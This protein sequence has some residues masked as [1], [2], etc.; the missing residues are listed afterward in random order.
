MRARVQR[1]SH[2]TQDGTIITLIRAGEGLIGVSTR[3][4]YAEGDTLEVEPEGHRWR[5]VEAEEG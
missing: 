5:A 1:P 2:T 3:R 4:R